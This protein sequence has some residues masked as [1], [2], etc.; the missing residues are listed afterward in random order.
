MSPFNEDCNHQVEVEVKIKTPG[1]LVP[2]RDKTRAQHS[3]LASG[4]GLFDT[5]G[6][7]VLRKPVSK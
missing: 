4:C 3:S 1:E 7:S 2:Y 5:G 6:G